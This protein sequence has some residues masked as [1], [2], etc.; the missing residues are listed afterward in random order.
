VEYYAIDA[1]GNR[2]EVQSAVLWKDDSPPV[3]QPSVPG[4]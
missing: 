4:R 2:E 1:Y 3:T